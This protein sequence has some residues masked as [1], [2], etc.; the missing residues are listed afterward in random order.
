[1]HTHFVKFYTPCFP[2][3][4]SSNALAM[5]A[6]GHAIRLAKLSLCS[7]GMLID[8]VPYHRASVE[9]MRRVDQRHP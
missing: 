6:N 2:Q 4:V 5:L 9:R 8:A 1:M 3:E 7:A